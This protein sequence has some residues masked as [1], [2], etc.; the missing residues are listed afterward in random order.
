MSKIYAKYIEGEDYIAL[1]DEEQN[2]ISSK[3]FSFAQDYLDG[4]L[5]KESG[6]K[7]MYYYV[8]N[9]GR[10]SKPYYKSSVPI[11][12]YSIV[13]LTPKSGPQ[14][15]DPKGNLSEEYCNLAQCPDGSI[16]S[17]IEYGS[18][19]RLHEP[20]GNI[21]QEFDYISPESFAG[22][23][24]VSNNKKQ[25]YRIRYSDGSLGANTYKEM[26]PFDGY[27]FARAK[28]KGDGQPIIYVDLLGRVSKDYTQSGADYAELLK[29]DIELKDMNASD[30][31]DESFC[32]EIRKLFIN[33]YKKEIDYYFQHNIAVN[34]AT[35]K[36][37][38]ADVEDTIDSKKSQIDK[39]VFDKESIDAY[40]DSLIK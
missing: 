39:S 15:R 21:S 9:Y 17:Q 8:D 16:I 32:N 27:G 5:V 19:K 20:N 3:E 35:V 33:R 10:F 31:N 12:G 23:R 22:I 40:L 6:E 7:G 37:W 14:I 24:V 11:H 4:I 30:F 34:L 25:S 29:G 18:K 1:F 36:R 2:L 28:N 13:Q 38:M 26:T